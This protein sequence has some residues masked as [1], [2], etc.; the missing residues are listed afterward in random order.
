M[1][2]SENCTVKS[3]ISIIIKSSSSVFAENYRYLMFKYNLSVDDWGGE[4]CYLI[5]KISLLQRQRDICAQQIIIGNV[6][7]LCNIR[8]GVFST[9]LSRTN[10]QV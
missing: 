7:E 1:L 8:D 9:E 10:I 6:R 3:I 4:L 2:N 5:E